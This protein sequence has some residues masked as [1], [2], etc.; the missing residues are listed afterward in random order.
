[1]SRFLPWSA[2]S[3]LGWQREREKTACPPSLALSLVLFAGTF[4]EPGVKL[5]FDDFIMIFGTVIRRVSLDIHFAFRTCEI[6]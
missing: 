1:M 3:G 6:T 4:G 2:S 5:M